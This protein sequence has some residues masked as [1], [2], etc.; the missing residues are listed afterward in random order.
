VQADT[1]AAR[2]G[3]A[4]RICCTSDLHGH[5]PEIPPCDLLILAGD[6][7]PH[8]DGQY[9]WLRD[10]FAPWVAAI[11][12][13]IPV[14]GIAGNHDLL[15]E[16]KKVPIPRI[17]WTYLEDEATSINGLKIYGS[18]WQPRFFDWAFNLD[19]GP[20]LA[21]KWAMIP[22]DTDILITHSPPLGIRDVSSREDRIGSVSLTKRLVELPKLRLHVFGH[23]HAGYG[24]AQFQDGTFVNAAHVDEQY[25]PVNPPLVVEIDHATR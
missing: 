3:E 19:E 4:M 22:D 23:N 6:Y 20:E 13:R 12:E 15:F 2:L 18:P 8:S 14:V 5:L 1:T 11:A 24:I 10:T 16:Q 9:W 7:C 17:E 25:R 21:A